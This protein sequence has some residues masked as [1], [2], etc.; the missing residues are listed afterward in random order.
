MDD[1][2][3]SASITGMASLYEVMRR[4]G[5]LGDKPPWDELGDDGRAEWDRVVAKAV[6]A[7]RYAGTM[8]GPVPEPGEPRSP[9]IL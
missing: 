6:H 3:R 7:A 2:D 8:P 4:K 5:F 1:L 9:R